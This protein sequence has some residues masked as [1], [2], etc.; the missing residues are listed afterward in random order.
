MPYDIADA[1][2]TDLSPSWRIT[3]AEHHVVPLA[4]DIAEDVA[5]LI[6]DRDGRIK[7]QLVVRDDGTWRVD[8]DDTTPATAS[9]GDDGR[10]VYRGH[11]VADRRD[12]PSVVAIRLVDQVWDAYVRT[13][14]D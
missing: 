11:V 3:S 9:I 13:H 10:P 6:S 1:C 5:C 8:V 4:S 7:I 12:D 14:A 2:P